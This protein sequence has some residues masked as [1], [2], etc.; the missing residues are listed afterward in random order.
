M[1]LF[2]CDECGHIFSALDIEYMAT[3]CSVP[4]ECPKCHSRH[5]MPARLFSWLQKP[6]YKKIWA[7][8]DKASIDNQ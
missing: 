5:T 2:K 7:S 6:I 3:V 8:I 4:A 1:I